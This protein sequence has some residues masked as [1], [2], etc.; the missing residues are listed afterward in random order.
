MNLTREDYDVLLESM[1]AWENK[2]G[3]DGLMG[4]MLCGMLCRDD[5]ERRKYKEK[6][7]GAQHKR[8]EARR[9]RRDRSAVLRAKLIAQRDSDEAAEKVSP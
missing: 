8:D 9:V 6:E 2:D 1:E 5:D 7:R 3:M 4:A